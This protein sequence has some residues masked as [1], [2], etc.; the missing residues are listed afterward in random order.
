MKAQFRYDVLLIL[1]A[2]LLLSSSSA[3][4]Q[5]LVESA[6][7]ENGAVSVPTITDISVTFNKPL[8]QMSLP[9]ALAALTGGLP[10]DIGVIDPDCAV[11]PAGIFIIPDG[12]AESVSLSDDRRTVTMHNVEMGVDADQTML[13]LYATS[14]AGELL[15]MPHV[16]HFTTAPAIASGKISGLVSSGGPSP[17]GALVVAVEAP[18]AL[19]ADEQARS[20]H[21]G[22]ANGAGEYNLEFVPDGEYHIIG[23]QLEF[24]DPV[25]ALNNLL[26]GTVD[27]DAD[28]VADLITV[29]GGGAKS[30]ADVTLTHE[31]ST[32]SA[33]ND[34]ALALVQQE[35]ADAN[36]TLAVGAGLGTDGNSLSWAYLY[37]SLVQGGLWATAGI[38]SFVFPPQPVD[39][40]EDGDLLIAILGAY[41]IGSDFGDSDVAVTNYLAAGGEEFL[42]EYDFEVVGAAIVM[43]ADLFEFIRLILEGGGLD[44]VLQP[45]RHVFDRLGVVPEFEQLLSKKTGEAW[46]VAFVSPNGPG[47][48]LVAMDDAGNPLLVIGSSSARENEAA[49]EIVA[50]AWS[51]DVQLV[52][53]T[54]S[55][56]PIDP[57]G[58]SIAWSFNYYSASRDSVISIT[59]SGA[60]LGGVFDAF[61]IPK[62]EVP[63]VSPLPDNWI[64]SPAVVLASRDRGVPFVVDHLSSSGSA[65]LSRGLQVGN[66]AAAIWRVRLVGTTATGETDM[67]DI[68][69]DAESGVYVAVEDDVAQPTTFALGQNYPNPF[70]PSTTIPYEVAATSL[71]TLEV[72]DALGRK[73]ATLVNET[74]P[75]GSYETSWNARDSFG[76]TAPS[77][78]YLYRLAIDGN[79][80]SRT[81]T[82]LK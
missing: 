34:P 60:D 18:F 28:H 35:A 47:L 19:L 37:T 72:Y 73:V 78:I 42:E 9:P 29:A 14:Q 77:G 31:G 8:A 2:I 33:L 15:T 36:L 10:I 16:T 5:L 46:I 20:P 76:S 13:V 49:A 1:A 53:V 63:S 71:V 64:D 39:L 50:S 7:I 61:V 43:S 74:R 25:V 55:E 69:L 82:L 54:T 56:L 40:G 23:L 27:A 52:S 51:S 66:P 48:H 22:F 6:S 57:R 17:E 75:S 11:A 65:I 67:L 58:N 59:S 44:G 38:G 68:D 30:G 41:P 21:L 45:V 24:S 70:N 80:T 79:V 26:I 62:E 3:K 4:A 12:C 32:A 81:M